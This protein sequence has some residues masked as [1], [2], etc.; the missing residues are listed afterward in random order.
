MLQSGSSTF[1]SSSASSTSITIPHCHGMV[2]HSQAGPERARLSAGTYEANDPLSVHILHGLA[3]TVGSALGSTPPSN[4]TCLAAFIAPNKVGLTAGARAWSKHFH[5]S[6]TEET[7][8]SEVGQR[9]TQKP[10]EAGNTG[11]WGTPSGPVVV[12]NEKALKL[13]RKVMDNA[14]WRNLHWLPHQ[15]LIY[16]VRVPDGYGMRWSQDQSDEAQTT[17]EVKDWVFRGFLEPQMKNGHEVGW[18]H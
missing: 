4:E 17:V 2:E 12:I 5:R 10:A 6:Q 9:M 3:Y 7:P 15:V 13:F 1:S 14:S 8:D 18:R 11:W 16:E